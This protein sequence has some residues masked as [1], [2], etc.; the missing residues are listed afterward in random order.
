MADTVKGNAK[1]IREQR[2]DLTAVAGNLY[3][4]VKL[5]MR[6]QTVPAMVAHRAKWKEVLLNLESI[7]QEVKE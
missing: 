5:L 4:L 7:K 6:D 3:D 1:K 2:E